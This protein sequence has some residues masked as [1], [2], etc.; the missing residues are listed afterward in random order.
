MITKDDWDNAWINLD[1]HIDIG[2]DEWDEKGP[3]AKH[4]QRYSGNV[5]VSVSSDDDDLIERKKIGT[6]R[7]TLFQIDRCVNDSISATIVADDESQELI[8][9]VSEAINGSNSYQKGVL[10]TLGEESV[11]FMYNLLIIKEIKIEPKYRGHKLCLKIMKMLIESIG[12]NAVVIIKPFPLQ[13]SGHADMEDGELEESLNDKYYEGFPKD[14]DIALKN[15]MKYY[16]SMGFK[17]LPRSTYMVTT[18][19]HLEEIE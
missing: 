2:Q 1:L 9:Y 14:F 12:Y 13:F 4:F 15:M 7:A 18:H 6:V 8:E 5:L 10:R 16:K 3:R 11:L 19:E 17:K